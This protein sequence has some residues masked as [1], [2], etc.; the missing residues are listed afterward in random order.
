M[1][2]LEFW[3][4]LGNIFDAVM[5]Y[6]KKNVE[7]NSRFINPWIRLGNIF[8]RQDQANDA[9]EAYQR[10]IE[11][12]PDSTQNWVEL[13]DAQFKKGAYN[14]A[15]EAYG[16]AVTLDPE[17]G[18][19]L[20]NLALSMVT[21]GK[22]EEAIPLYKKSIDLLTEVKDK[23]ICWNRL[24][25]AYRKL[26]NYEDAFLAFQRADQLDGENT[27]FSDKLDEELPSTS[28]VAPEE[29]LEQMVEDQALEAGVAETTALEAVEETV[30]PEVELT[31][32]NIAPVEIAEEPVAL[33]PNMEMKVEENIVEEASLPVAESVEPVEE[34]TQP[35]AEILQTVEEAAQSVAES[36]ELV[37]ETTQPVAEVLQPVEEAAQSV[38]ESVELVEEVSQLLETSVEEPV[39]QNTVTEEETP[40]TLHEKKFN[41][42]QIVEDVIAKVERAYAEHKAPNADEGQEIEKVSIKAEAPV[43]SE[44]VV[45]DA[46]QEFENPVVSKDISIEAEAPVSSEETAPETVVVAAEIKEEAKPEIVSPIASTANEEPVS[47]EEP[48]RVPA[49]L[50]IPDEVKV[51][52]KLAVTE[53]AQI[54]SVT[55]ISDISQ[56]IAVSESVVNM[57]IVET[58]TD[59]LAAQLPTEPAQSE[60]P[61]Q[62]IADQSAVSAEPETKVG[63]SE[64]AAVDESSLVAEPVVA[65]E[66]TNEVAYEEYLKDMVEPTNVLTDHVDEMQG[67]TPLTKVSKNGEV[68]IAMDTKNAHVWNEL[69]NIYLNAGTY[70]DAI[71]SYS[72][73]IELDRQFAWPY[74]NL[75]LAYVQKGRFAEAILLYQRGIELFTSDSDKA[76]T[77]NRLGNVY[78]RIN[79]YA[80]AI[81]SYQT[82]DE[83]DPEN[84]TLSLRS[85]FGLLGN[86]HPES[87]PAY[88]A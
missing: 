53:I 9:V 69:G 70:D 34:T 58:Y 24:G 74:S 51:E 68:R 63:A 64:M 33:A 72:K 76:I 5:D 82:A 15:I 32:I 54:E 77:W 19:P 84:A 25:N 20:G 66:K 28:V 43:A 57:D 46:V 41:L 23:A 87:K 4:D 80:N 88:I 40:L 61:I 55:T 59:S 21:V 26:N 37:E 14:E 47:E 79:D 60:E 67:E 30:Q 18:W 71:A 11:I 29:I 86:M 3:K 35:V 7:F 2:E 83:L 17:A 10:A 81:A 16:K 49:W 42:V 52:E 38:A 48:R 12:D 13:G 31:T 22:I 6:Q 39:N 44:E 78:R 56:E 50:V 45:Q 27:G 8:E 65:E 73:A 1:S 36:V 75:A 62:E 85:S